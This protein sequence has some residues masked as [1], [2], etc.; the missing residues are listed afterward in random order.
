MVVEIVFEGS[1]PPSGSLRIERRPPIRFDGW[2]ELMGKLA[3]VLGV[4][5]GVSKGGRP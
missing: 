4:E 5:P 3:L 2:M 1:E